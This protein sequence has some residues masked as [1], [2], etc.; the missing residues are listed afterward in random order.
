MRINRAKIENFRLLRDVEIGFEEQ[1][2]LIV[3]RNNSGKIMQYTQ[4]IWSD[5]DTAF[6][7]ADTVCGSIIGEPA[8]LP[9]IAWFGA[10]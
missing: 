5:Y 1:T 9:G 6:G 3:G 10:T 8:F 2:T 4:R 7:T